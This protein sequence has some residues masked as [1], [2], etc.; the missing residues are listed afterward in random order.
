MFGIPGPPLSGIPL[1]TSGRPVPALRGA[2]TSVQNNSSFYVESFNGSCWKTLRRRLAE[3]DAVVLCAQELGISDDFWGQAASSA[4]GLGWHALLLPARLN[5]ETGK[6]SSGVGVFARLAVGLRWPTE[7]GGDG[8]IVAHRV[9]KVLLDFPGWPTVSLY[10][11]YLRS[12]EGLSEANLS[13]LKA[14]GRSVLDS[15]NAIIGGAWN[16]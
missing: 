5:P 4:R 6:L 9:I 1:S 15:E 16:L 10:S 7:R 8:C 13:I 3:T 14:L 2:P 12:A 11:V